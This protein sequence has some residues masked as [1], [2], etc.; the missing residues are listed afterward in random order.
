MKFLAIPLLASI[1][2]CSVIFL[3]KLF[4]G[5]TIIEIDGVYGAYPFEIREAGFY[6]LWVYGRVFKKLPLTKLNVVIHN[7][8]GE[9]VSMIPSF[10][11]AQSNN[12][13]TGSMQLK[14]GYLKPGQY[15]LV[16]QEGIEETLNWMDKAFEKISGGIPPS[17]LRYR[18][19]KTLPEF[20][21][22]FLLLGILAPIFG[23][24]ALLVFR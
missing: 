7:H 6:S 22:P 17:A 24:L 1:T 18:I 8:A 15:S 9:R 19:K 12:G 20:A 13:T 4:R 11:R 2:I 16:L 23:I 21:F 10:L 3:I 14:Y 5:E